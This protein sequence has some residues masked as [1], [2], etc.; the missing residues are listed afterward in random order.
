MHDLWQSLLEGEADEWRLLLEEAEQ[1]GEFEMKHEQYI[2]VCPALVPCEDEPTH[3]D[4]HP[5]CSDPKCPCH[6]VV[7]DEHMNEVYHRFIA[8]PLLA[9]LI[10]AK[11]ANRIFFDE[12]I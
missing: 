6:E 7:T 12:Q 11:E 9:G 3:T 1:I 5:W 10:T 4:E 8:G 2:Q